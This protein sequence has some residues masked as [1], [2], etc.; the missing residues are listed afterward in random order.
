MSQLRP[1]RHPIEPRITN[2][3]CVDHLLSSGHRF[4]D[5]VL[6]Y[7]EIAAYFIGFFDQF[8]RGFLLMVIWRYIAQ[9]SHF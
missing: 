5:P 8:L 4:H 9:N 7:A 3:S 2:K 1:L 6:V